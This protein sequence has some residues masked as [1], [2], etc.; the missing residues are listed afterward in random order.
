MKENKQKAE[1]TEVEACILINNSVILL[2]GNSE[3]IDEEPQ[4]LSDDDRKRVRS[5]LISAIVALSVVAVVLVTG[6]FVGENRIAREAARQARDELMFNGAYPEEPEDGKLTPTLAQAFYTV[7]DGMQLV[8][9]FTNL[10][11]KDQQVNTA[12]ITIYDESDKLIAKGGYSGKKT[13]CT[14]PT[15]ESAQLELYLTP[16][17]VFITNDDFDTLRWEIE[18]GVVE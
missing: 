12:I 9:D 5:M 15:G 4:A 8:L 18:V 14:V 10:T 6:Y 17:Y 7:E 3:T 16:E 1:T 11:D 2:S 13:I